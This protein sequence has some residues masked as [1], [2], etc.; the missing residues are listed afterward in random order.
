MVI[1]LDIEKENKWNE[2]NPNFTNNRFDLTNPQEALLLKYIVNNKEFIIPIKIKSFTIDIG[3]YLTKLSQEEFE[4]LIKLI[5]KKFKSINRLRIS[6]SLNNYCINSQFQKNIDYVTILPNAVEEFFS[7][8]S[9]QTRYN[10]NRKAKKL[11]ND[12]ADIKIKKYTDL[13]E[14][15][16]NRIESYLGKEIV[17]N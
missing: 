15:C 3:I 9:S 13:K 2:I 5:F 10:L 17:E 8:L 14:N 12:F 4:N 6:S 11:Y 7:N 1:S 16:K